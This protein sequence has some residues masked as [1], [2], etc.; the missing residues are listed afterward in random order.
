MAVNELNYMARS[1][2]LIIFVLLVTFYLVRQASAWYLIR[3]AFLVADCV[4]FTSYMI[5]QC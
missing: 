3:R 2:I 1:N 4:L 5:A